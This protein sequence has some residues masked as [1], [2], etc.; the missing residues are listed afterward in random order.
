MN[1][2]AFIVAFVPLLSGC[3][4]NT[5]DSHQVFPE[6][7]DTC[8]CPENKSQES[9]ESTVEEDIESDAGMEEEEEVEEEEVEEVIKRSFHVTVYAAAD[10]EE[11]RVT[12][13]YS[14]DEPV[15]MT[16]WILYDSELTGPSGDMRPY[17]F[18]TV[19]QDGDEVTVYTVKD[20]GYQ[21]HIWNRDGDTVFIE[22]ADGEIIVEEEL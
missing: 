20:W 8:E 19:L 10:I 5:E 14:G 18:D 21:R 4:V 1:R 13:A 15:D 11:E 2:R 9:V 16:G 22:D 6:E 3:A 12:I 7:D 17:T